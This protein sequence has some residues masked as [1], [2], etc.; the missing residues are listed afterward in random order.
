MA[1]RIRGFERVLDAPA[2]FAIA[3]GE[4]G[5]SIYVA[6]GIVAGAALGL[7]PVVLALTGV[8]FLLVALSYAEGTAALPE[9]GGAATFTR[10][11][12]NDLVGFVTGWALFLDYLIVISLSALF[13]PH[14]VGAGLGID[15]LRDSPWDTIVA[16]GAVAAIGGVRL[17]RRSRLYL[18]ALVVAL[19]DLAVQGLIVILGLALVFSPS[20]LTD[21]FALAPGQ[22]WLDDVVYAIPLG[23]VAYTGLETV[24][25][26]AEEAREPGTTLPRSLFSAIGLVVVLTVLVAMVGV[27]AFPAPNGTTELGES[28][29]EAPLVGIVSAFGVELPSGVVDVL[30]GLVG[31]SAALILVMSV[32]TSISGCA[33]LAH[34]MGT[35]GMLPRELGRLERRTLVSREAIAAIT[36]VAIAVLLVASLIP[37]EARFL[38]GTYSF[39]VLLAFT[40]AQ[41]AVIRLRRREPDLARPFRA[42]PDVRIRGVA[43]PLPAL[44][45]APLT[46]AVFVIALVTHE[47]ARY[48]G[49]AWIAIG[50]VIFVL[51]RMRAKLGVL[52]DVDPR[53]ALPAGISYERILV[54]M[55]LGVIGEEMVATAIALAKERGARVEAITV[56]PVPRERTLE[57]PL[58][59]SLARAAAESIAEARALGEENEVEVHADAVPARSIGY[60]IVDEAAR[61]RADLIV[62]G[63]SPRWRR[64]SRFF[65]PTVDYVLKHAPCEVLV[66][67]FPEGVFEE[68]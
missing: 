9:T 34:S 5:A 1:R 6:L 54:P 30:E 51:T 44:V 7:T 18:P 39:G 13:L 64:Q 63:S 53:I 49:P 45:G 43:V 66:V 31:L 11:A 3:Y 14:Y 16:I 68:E 57:A 41:L 15:T 12:F 61:R 8:V 35:H 32:T 36:L 48:A 26:L 50:L 62:L 47:S 23:F 58:P 52:A 27:T 59:E 21:G 60:A 22:D 2:L 40:L 10:R 67:A 4:I 19:L 55:K 65:S 37:D 42:R 38:A 24:A 20:V 25:N 29:L 17:A 56:V 28:W 46:A 33:R